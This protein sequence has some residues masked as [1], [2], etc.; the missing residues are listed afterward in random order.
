[1][2]FLNESNQHRLY[3]IIVVATPMDLSIAFY[4]FTVPDLKSLMTIFFKF[5]VVIGM[6]S[7]LFYP[8]Y[9]YVH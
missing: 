4:L 9:L 5:D 2:I 6:H 7:V 8:I 3:S 1:M